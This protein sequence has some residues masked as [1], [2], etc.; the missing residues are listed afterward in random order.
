LL[1]KVLIDLRVE[2]ESMLLSDSFLLLP[3]TFYSKAKI[4]CCPI[5]KCTYEPGLIF[6]NS[7]IE[8]Q[9]DAV[10]T[11]P[12][13]CSEQVQFYQAS[14]EESYNSMLNRKAIVSK[15][16]ETDFRLSFQDEH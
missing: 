10:A 1:F 3:E 12:F 6:N 9:S 8:Y 4:C 13:T 5:L 11:G 7:N 2:A 16:E 14:V 15:V